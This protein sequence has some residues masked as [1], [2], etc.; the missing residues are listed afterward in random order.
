[1]HAALSAGRDALQQG[2]RRGA[3]VAARMRAVLERGPQ[4]RIDYAAVVDP[5]TLA[6]VEAVDG[7]VLL[8]VAAFVG[9]TRL[10]DNLVLEAR[11]PEV[12]DAT[13]LGSSDALH[14][15]GKR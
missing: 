5:G 11:G 7:R 1:L 9:Q 14:P 12:R 8:A 13:L 3:A 4:V 6:P 2:E 10:I 15:G